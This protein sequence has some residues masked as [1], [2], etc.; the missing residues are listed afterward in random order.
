MTISALVVDL[1]VAAF[2]AAAPPSTKVKAAPLVVDVA[3]VTT[4]PA[5]PLDGAAVDAGRKL[6]A[7]RCQACHGVT[8]AGDG[9]VGR[10]L[11]PTPQ[12]FSDALWQARVTD[13]ELRQAI[14]LGGA[15][16][17]KSA[18]MPAAKDLSPD[19]VDALIAFVRSLRAPHGTA[20][21]TVMKEDGHDVVVN[22]DASA[23]GHA[24]V[25]VPGV[26]G[27]VTVLG[28]VDA[29]GAPVCA[30]DVAEAA[31][32]HVACVAKKKP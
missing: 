29:T 19:A 16:V 9:P 27:H 2:V 5:R 11:K 3:G 14:V 22:V 24:H 18:S 12:A 8:G 28:V 13:D 30:L 26:A 21:V 25:V 31:G 20:S 15:A 6:Y 17:K 7:A 4:P 10:A 32:A 23:D 1:A